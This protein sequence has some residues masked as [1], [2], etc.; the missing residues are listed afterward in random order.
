MRRKDNLTTEF[1]FTLPRGLIDD[2]QR[3]NRQGLMRLAT[4]KDEIIVQQDSTVRE[5]PAYGVLVMLSRVITRL[6]SYTSV[7]PDLLENLQIL[8]IAFL[9]EYYNQVN[10]QG[11]AKIPTQCPHCNT[12]FAVKLELAGES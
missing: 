5:N 12:Q 3:V 10:Q 7:T 11:E 4:A 1:S 9:R 6:G 2:R 8:D